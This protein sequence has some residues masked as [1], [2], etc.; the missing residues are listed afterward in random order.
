MSQLQFV[1][2]SSPL[3]AAWHCL[4]LLPGLN[5]VHGCNTAILKNVTESINSA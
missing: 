1:L 3:L 5:T 4:L 2:A